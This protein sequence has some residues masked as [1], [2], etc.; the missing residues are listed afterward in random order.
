[1]TILSAGPSQIELVGDPR[2]QVVLLVAH[3][4]QLAG[5]L[6]HVGSRVEVREEVR[7]VAHAGEDTDRSVVR[8]RVVSRALERLPGRFEKDTLLRI[9]DLGLARA[10][11]E[12]L[13]I[14]QFHSVEDPSRTHVAG[15][16][17]LLH[18]G[19]ARWLQLVLGEVGDRLLSRHE[20]LPELLDVARARKATSQGNDRNPL[21][22]VVGVCVGHGYCF[23][24]AALIRDSACFCLSARS[25]VPLVAIPSLAAAQ[26]ARQRTN[27]RVLEGAVTGRSARTSP[28]SRS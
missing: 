15:I 3:H 18:V 1:M 11:P 6:Q 23:P 22:R 28:R 17:A 12:E 10:H 20:V 4:R 19:W 5:A 2:G 9:D 21:L 25:F 13:R 8:L 27:R 7:V 24:L 26:V 14:E 16:A